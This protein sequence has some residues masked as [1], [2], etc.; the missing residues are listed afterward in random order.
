MGNPSLGSCFRPS[1]A[2][3]VWDS[4]GKHKADLQRSSALNEWNSYYKINDIKICRH[5]MVNVP[6]NLC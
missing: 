2:P 3:D 6:C 5:V 4:G 1:H